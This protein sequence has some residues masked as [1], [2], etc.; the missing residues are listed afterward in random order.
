M[1]VKE[2]IDAIT[3][4]EVK[5]LISEDSLKTLDNYIT[6][7]KYAN[8]YNKL[9]GIEYCPTKEDAANFEAIYNEIKAEILAFE[10]SDNANTIKGY[11]DNNLEYYFQHAEE[12]FEAEEE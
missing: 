8:V 7:I 10:S 4:S 5:G 3:D 1:E 6:A 2:L 11:L 9:K 12:L